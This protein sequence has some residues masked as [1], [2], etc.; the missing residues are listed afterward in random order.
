[1]HDG[2][3]NRAY[4]NRVG[5][6]WHFINLFRIMLCPGPRAH[7]GVATF[8]QQYFSNAYGSIGIILSYR[9]K[10]RIKLARIF[11][12]NNQLNAIR[13]TSIDICVMTWHVRQTYGASFLRRLLNSWC[14]STSLSTEFGVVFFQSLCIYIHIITLFP[15]IRKSIEIH[16]V[17]GSIICFSF[18]L[19]LHPR[20]SLFLST[21]LLYGPA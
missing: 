19:S 8:L 3:C 7:N 14:A 20:I 4:C 1:M 6:N 2:L 9:D 13:L 15:P 12:T 5:F 17:D 18:S 16:D 11:I 21:F 10:Y